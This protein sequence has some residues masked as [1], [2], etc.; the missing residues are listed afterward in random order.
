MILCTF[1]EI[2]KKDWLR[3]RSGHKYLL[4]FKVKFILVNLAS[5]TNRLRELNPLFKVF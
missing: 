3:C 4:H 5:I 2:L 1:D